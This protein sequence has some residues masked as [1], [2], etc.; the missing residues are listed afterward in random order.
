M[1]GMNKEFI[2]KNT[3]I[4]FFLDSGFFWEMLPMFP[5]SSAVFL[6]TEDT[7]SCVGPRWLLEECLAF[8][9]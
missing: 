2:A 4:L 9:R 1:G 7:C 3:P 6:S 5:D 8:S